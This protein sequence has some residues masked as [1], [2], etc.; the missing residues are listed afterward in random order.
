MSDSAAT[1]RVVIPG[2]L[3]DSRGSKPGE[4]TYADGGHVYAAQLGI[5]A[6]G[7]G[8]VSVI[9]LGGRYMPR[10]DDE[11]IGQVVDLGPSHWLLDINAPYPAPLHATESPWRVDFGDTGRYMD[12]GDSAIC[13]VLQVD[14]TKRVQCTMQ[15]RELHKIEGGQIVEV[16]HSKVPRI[17]GKDG[18]MI[19]LIKSFTKIQGFVGQNGRIW[20]DG[21]P[22]DVMIA[23]RVIKLIEDHAQAVGLTEAVNAFL[24]E[25]Y[26]GRA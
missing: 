19:Q 4:G 26:A 11:V 15:D 16:S 20:I 2:E 7:D 3:I 24:K 13:R 1:R 10:A 23:T 14:E 9:P 17:I 18:S 6:Q 8:L 25:A 21:N 12:I 5:V 22:E